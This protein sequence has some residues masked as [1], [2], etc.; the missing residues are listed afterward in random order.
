[1]FPVVQLAHQMMLVLNKEHMATYS[2]SKP[3]INPVPQAG[4][5]LSSVLG[6]GGQQELAAALVWKG[7]PTT[8]LT[9]SFFSTAVAGTICM[10]LL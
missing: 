6:L 7:S 1:M 8:F 5:E 4:A 3:Y 2:C 9:I 10:L